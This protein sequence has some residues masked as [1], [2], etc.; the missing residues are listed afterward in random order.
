MSSSS[1]SVSCVVLRAQT[2]SGYDEKNIRRRIYDALNVLMAMEIIGKERKQIRWKGF[3]N[4]LGMGINDG[5]GGAAAAAA[6]A[7]AKSNGDGAASS[8]V[9]ERDIM[10][11]QRSIRDR[12]AAID[13]KKKDLDSLALQYVACNSLIARNGRP[14][15]HQAC[16]DDEKIRLPFTLLEAEDTHPAEVMVRIMLRTQEI[17]CV[18]IRSLVFAHVALLCLSLL[19]LVLR[20]LTEG[21]R[22]HDSSD[23][24]RL[25][26]SDLPQRAMDHAVDWR[27]IHGAP[28]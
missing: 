6:A 15:A 12:R 5:T 13:Q 9:S 4:C 22:E 20:A 19:C 28:G 27:S 24:V 8:I 3:E 11:V 21:R 10:A 2:Y 7:A 18:R 1:F 14:G 26:S 17:A 23:R 16:P 25:E